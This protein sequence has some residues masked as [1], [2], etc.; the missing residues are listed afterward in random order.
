MFVRVLSVCVATVLGTVC[1]AGAG[2]TVRPY[3]AS[4]KEAV[5]DMTFAQAERF[6]AGYSL[7]AQGLISQQEVLRD[8]QDWLD[9][10]DLVDH[11]RK[12]VLVWPDRS[13]AVGFVSYFKAREQSL[14]R[15][16]VSFEQLGLVM[17]EA[18]LAAMHPTMKKTDAECSMYAHL[19]ALVIAQS[20]QGKG[21]GRLLLRHALDR[22]HQL[23]PEVRYIQLNV[24]RANDTA[25]HLYESEGFQ[26]L[27]HQ[28]ADMAM[29]EAIQ[30]RKELSR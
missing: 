20:M 8:Q 15:L 5:K 4:D 28:P 10:L 12:E 13:N 16:K 26:A 9:A 23:W 11:K 14:E 30:Y 19:D 24:N 22:I 6:F 3:V 25:R 18:S 1:H 2:C 29:I 17:D 7:V 21:C 27:E